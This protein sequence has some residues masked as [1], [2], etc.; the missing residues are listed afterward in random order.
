MPYPSKHGLLK[1]VGFF[2][3]E[4]NDIQGMIQ[5]PPKNSP[6]Y[7]QRSRINIETSFWKI[8]KCSIIYN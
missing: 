4:E 5:K 3:L 8:I 1:S 7:F 6:T 2:H